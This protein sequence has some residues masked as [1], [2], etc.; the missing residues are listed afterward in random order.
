MKKFLYCLFCVIALYV[1]FDFAY[2]R[3]GFYIPTKNDINIISY[4]D[5]DK[6]YIKEN[7]QF[8]NITIKGVNIGG[9]I[10]GKYV[11]DYAITYDTFYAW[12]E[13]ISEMGANTI[14]L[15]TIFNSD[16]YNAFYDYNQNSTSKLYLVQGINLETY[17]LN[18]KK[19]AY[20][21][22]FY[23]E[24]IR[25]SEN[26]VDVI[27]GRKKMT[28]SKTGKGNYK[29]DISSYVLAYIVGSE[30]VDDTI[31]YTNKSHESE[32]IF[33]GNYLKTKENTP[34]FETMLTKV[35]DHLITYE[36]KKYSTQHMI[37]FINTPETDPVAAIP[38][39]VASEDS[40]EEKLIPENLKYF[41]HKIVE[42]DLEKVEQKNNYNG[43][44]AAYNVSSYY[45]NY[46]SY[47]N[48][49]YED[50][51]ESYLTRLNKHHKRPVLITE[52]A[53][54]TA[55]GISSLSNDNYGSFGGMTEENQGKSL[56]SAY[57][58]ILKSGSAGGIIAT[59]QD[60][61][62]KR[63]WN[64]I[65]K[66]DTTRSIYWSDAQ[67][68][69]QGLGLLT[70]D[71]G[72]NNSVCYIDGDVSEWEEK[73]KIH[74]DQNI[75]LS[76]KQDEKYLYLYIKKKN[77][78]NQ[79]Y[80]PLDITNKSGT[81]HSKN[82]NLTFNSDADFLIVLDGNKGELLVQDYYNPLR[83]IDSY[84]W[85]N[86]N[87]YVEPPKKDSDN[88]ESIYLITEPYGTNKFSH[89][90]KSAVT[91]NTGILTFGNANPNA[92]DFNSQADFY[93]ANGNIEIRIPWGLLNFSDPSKS[94]IHDDYYEKYGVEGIEIKE[95]FIGAGTSANETINLYPLELKPWHNNITYHERLKKSYDIVKN[96]WRDIS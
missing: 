14:R 62:D 30:W 74:E 39:I 3:W 52:F 92:K 44:F 15:N 83:A 38:E 36:T 86:Q 65:E 24:L 76:A 88:F 59:W 54:S 32:K 5:Q 11:T 55:R 56:V 46:L 19:D 84:E 42:L 94:K 31:L 33:E 66:V 70:F 2:Y 80:I 6:M 50:T 27:H 87:A 89:N 47:E 12:F 51:Y 90:Y 72:K 28:L 23:G 95:I 26:A 13:K 53:Y 9:S 20:D 91:V 57:K 64:T 1:L 81:K 25:Q 16:F 34:A 10:P 4:S 75:S 18:N 43:L 29:K 79:L 73:D 93:E 61:F 22:D 77:A 8:K 35:M 49:D 45:P 82:H 85:K 48:Q 68:S 60:E 58:T 41:Y 67:T 69:N 78:S 40:K 7:E 17:T 37:S 21:K 71:P 63:S 96:V